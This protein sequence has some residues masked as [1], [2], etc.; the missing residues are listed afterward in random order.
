MVDFADR[1]GRRPAC[2]IERERNRAL[3][4]IRSKERKETR[5]TIE[6]MA[7]VVFCGTYGDPEWRAA[8]SPDVRLDVDAAADELQK[9]GYKVYRLPDKYRWL[10]THPLDEFLE[11]RIEGKTGDDKLI[12]AI[13]DEV[14]A[15]VEKYGGFCDECGPV[16]P[17]RAPFADGA[18]WAEDPLFND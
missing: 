4:K 15:I 10:L 9:A 5:M 16:E 6:L 13:S 14:D 12:D 3:Y 2:L 17:D 1:G 8:F 18:D 11:L 7:N